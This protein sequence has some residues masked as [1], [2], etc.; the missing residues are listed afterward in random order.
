ML[1]WRSI[2]LGFTKRGGLA[3]LGLALNGMVTPLRFCDITDEGVS[4][5]RNVWL[6]TKKSVA[7]HFGCL[8]KNLLVLIYSE[9]HS[10]SCDYLY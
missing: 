3:C 7:N 5:S 6:E 2:S 1:A 10:K 4:I 8:L 9:L